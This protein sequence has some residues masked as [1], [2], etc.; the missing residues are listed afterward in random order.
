MPEVSLTRL[1]RNSATPLAD[2]SSG[3]SP[4][5]SRQ[6]WPKVSSVGVSR[7]S[8]VSRLILALAGEQGKAVVALLRPALE[9]FLG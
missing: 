1:A 3:P 5:S 9:Q 6:D 2:W 4:W 8:T 7:Y